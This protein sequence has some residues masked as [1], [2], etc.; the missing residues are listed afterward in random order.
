MKTAKLTCLCGTETEVRMS[1]NNN[2][3]GKAKCKC[4]RNITIHLRRH[5]AH[6]NDSPKRGALRGFVGRLIKEHEDSKIPSGSC[7]DW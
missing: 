5:K 3:D 4:G 2:A 1:G 7:G 6:I